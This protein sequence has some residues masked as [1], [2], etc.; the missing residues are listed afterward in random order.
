MSDEPVTSLERLRETVA[1]RVQATSLRTVARQVGMS[2]DR[3]ER[4][5]A[6]E[7]PY[8]SS[9]RRLQQ[10][11]TR[12]SSRPRTDVTVEGVEVAIGAL[13]RDLPPEHRVAAIRRVV[14]ALQRVYAE[15][16]SEPPE[17]LERLVEIWSR[18]GGDAP[19]E[20]GEEA[21]GPSAGG[22]ETP[23]RA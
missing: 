10:W 9:R 20:S 19:V 22:Q 11:W 2:P 14:A 4:F 3:L 8:S 23:P 21:E 15:Q 5:L 7:M 18:S 16:A 12:Q 17:W 13:V 1:L 6:G